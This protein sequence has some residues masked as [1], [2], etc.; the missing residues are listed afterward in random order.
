MPAMAPPLQPMARFAPFQGLGNLYTHRRAGPARVQG[1]T[2]E[3]RDLLTACHQL[4]CLKRWCL[5]TTRGGRA[6]AP[7]I[8]SH[9]SSLPHNA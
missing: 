8:I 4:L 9:P 2:I 7:L 6:F 3:I 1:A 5:K